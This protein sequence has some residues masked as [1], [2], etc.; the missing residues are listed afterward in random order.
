MTYILHVCHVCTRVHVCTTCVVQVPGIVLVNMCTGKTQ[1]LCTVHIF[2]K[3]IIQTFLLHTCVHT[4]TVHR[5]TCHVY[6][7]TNTTHYC[8]LPIVHTCMGTRVQV[9]M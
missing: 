7:Y 2:I 6:I 4:F 1:V 9:C 5:C 8:L 3:F